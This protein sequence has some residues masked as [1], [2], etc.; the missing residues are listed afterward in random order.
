LLM[1]KPDLEF[2]DLKSTPEKETAREIIRKAFVLGV[3]EINKWKSSHPQTNGEVPW[4]DYK[5]SYVGHL[6]RIEPLSIHI[7]HGGNHDIVN[8]HSRTHGPSWRMVVSL[9][10]DGVKPFATYPGGQ[11]GNPGSKHYNDLLKRWVQ[12]DYHPLLFMHHT[13]DFAGHTFSTTQLTPQ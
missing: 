8:A 7:R 2:F 13:N 3:D 5:D 12:D 6:L 4:A 11:S 1:E 9:E 10:K